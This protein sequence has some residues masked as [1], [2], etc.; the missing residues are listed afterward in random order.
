[1]DSARKPI[2]ADTSALHANIMKDKIDVDIV[3]STNEL[4][5]FN[6]KSKKVKQE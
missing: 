2:A 5:Q 1:M 6:W 4:D 3:S